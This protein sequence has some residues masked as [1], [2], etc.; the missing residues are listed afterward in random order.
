[1]TYTYNYGP[2]TVNNGTNSILTNAWHVTYFGNRGGNMGVGCASFQSF[3][4]EPDAAKNSRHSFIHSFRGG[5]VTMDMLDI[6]AAIA[7]TWSA[8]IVYDG[9]GSA[10]PGAGTTGHYSPF[11]QEGRFAYMN[12]Y[13]ASV[14]NQIYRYDVKNRVLSPHTPTDWIQSGTAAVGDR[15]ATYCAIDGTDKYSVVLLLAHTSNIAQELVVQV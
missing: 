3:G 7:G 2:A 10:T 11:D 1:V 12:I 5:A 9:S 8:A 14:I 13:T 4:I 6:A 15:I